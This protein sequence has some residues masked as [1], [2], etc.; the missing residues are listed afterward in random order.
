MATTKEPATPAFSDEQKS[1]LAEMIAEAVKGAK[2]PEQ[3]APAPAGPR[4]VTD[5]EWDTMSDRARESWVR[6]LVDFRLEELGRQDADAE[7]DRKI[8]ELEKAK[9]AAEA[10]PG[11][12]PPTIIDKLRGF[13]WGSEPDKP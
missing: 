7:R 10:P 4:A 9:A 8:A 1:E 12:R 5:A 13:L 11:D 6:Q 2:P 3:P